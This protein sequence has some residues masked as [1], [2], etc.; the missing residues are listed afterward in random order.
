MKHVRALGCSIML[1][2]GLATSGFAQGTGDIVGRVSDASGGVLPG[3]TVT[4]TSRATNISR[5]TVTS[6]TGDFSELSA[7]ICDP[8]TRPRTPFPGNIIPST[9]FDARAAALMSLYP[10]PTNS[11]LANN[12]AYNGRGTQTNQTMD[13]RIDHRFSDTDS[14]YRIGR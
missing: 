14:S 8:L 1:L 11:G 10:M 7:P 3:V 2:L 12:F 9:R 6:D 5:T 13:V 4:A